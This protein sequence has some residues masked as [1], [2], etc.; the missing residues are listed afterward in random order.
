MR[1]SELLHCNRCRWNIVRISKR[2]W[3]STPPSDL[4]SGTEPTIGYALVSC[5]S[6]T[7]CL[8]G[9]SEGR[10]RTYDGRHWA[11]TPTISGDNLPGIAP[12]PSI[13]DISCAQSN[14]CVAAGG[15]AA[16]TFE[17]G[18]WQ[19]AQTVGS[20]ISEISC[21]TSKFCIALDGHGYA[22]TFS[23]GRWSQS[24]LVDPSSPVFAA[25]CTTTTFCAAVDQE[26][27]AMIDRTV[28]GHSERTSIA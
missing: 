11:D 5:S 17:G 9:N 28:S 3:H 7:F 14:F 19:A 6:D 1:E 24:H 23:D 25:S 22:F 27:Y 12:V 26:G 18:K 16:V 2:Y 15:N 21:P 8:G 13:R 10:T 4:G 20:G